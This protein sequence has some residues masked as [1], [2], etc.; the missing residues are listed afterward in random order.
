[1]E[2][3]QILFQSFKHNISLHV[4]YPNIVGN[5]LPTLKELQQH[6][7]P[8]VADKWYHLG[9]ALLDEKKAELRT[10]KHD[11]NNKCKACCLAMFEYWLQIQP[12]ATWN[13]LIEALESPCVELFTVAAN[14]RK[15]FTGMLNETGLINLSY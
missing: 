1:M 8:H 2:T 12:S 4:V 15:L 5:S 7:V 6:V 10:I 14:L 9:V 11:N 3:Q 13:S